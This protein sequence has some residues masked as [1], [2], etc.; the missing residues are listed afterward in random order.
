MTAS[1]FRSKAVAISAAL[2]V[3][4]AAVGIGRWYLGSAGIP[5]R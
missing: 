1:T 2:V 4:A 5:S 3:L